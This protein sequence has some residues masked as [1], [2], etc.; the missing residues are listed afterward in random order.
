MSYTSNILKTFIPVF[1]FT[2]ISNILIF[3]TWREIKD[4]WDVDILQMIFD[5][6]LFSHNLNNLREYLEDFFFR[7]MHT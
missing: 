5:A 6:N 7:K 1:V 3:L 2:A 4:K